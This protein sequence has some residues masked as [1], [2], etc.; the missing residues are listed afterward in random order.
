MDEGD[1]QGVMGFEDLMSSGGL[2]CS[3]GF[4]SIALSITA[5]LLF[6]IIY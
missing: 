1:M 4:I 6:N 5:C 3:T 2:K